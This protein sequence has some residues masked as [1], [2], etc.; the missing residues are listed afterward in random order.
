MK[1]KIVC[2][3]G[4]VVEEVLPPDPA[5]GRRHCIVTMRAIRKF[6]GGGSGWISFRLIGGDPERCSGGGHDLPPAVAMG[7]KKWAAAILRDREARQ[8]G[9]SKK[10]RR[11]ERRHRSRAR[12]EDAS[13]G[14]IAA[15]GADGYELRA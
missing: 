14:R 11:D 7:M 3:Y 12:Q 13:R 2:G 9:L 8:S 5:P 1:E 15:G 4:I 10:G 6:D